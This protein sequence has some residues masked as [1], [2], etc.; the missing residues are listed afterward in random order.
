[1]QMQFA[2][3]PS[4]PAEN[5][6]SRAL[7]RL[8]IARHPYITALFFLVYWL[9]LLLASSRL[10]SPIYYATHMPLL[11]YQMFGEALLALIVI[12]PVALLGWWPEVGL[13]R[14]VNGRGILL[15][16]LPA[17][18]IVGPVLLALPAVVGNAT[19]LVLVVSLVLSLLVGFA[20]EGMFRG[21]ILRSLLPKGIWPA[22]L[23]STL[24]FAS[25]HL[26]N[27]LGGASW[28]YVFDQLILT[29]G[30]GV[31]F[32]ALRLRT[33]SL[34]PGILLHAAR[35]IVGMII[36]G[37]N[38]TVIRFTPSNTTYI[39]TLVFCLIFLFI[40]SVLLRTSQVRKLEIAYGLVRQT[41]AVVPNNLFYSF[42]QGYPAY[43]SSGDQPFPATPSGNQPLPYPGSVSYQEYTSPDAYRTLPPS[44]ETQ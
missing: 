14:G 15:C 1:M 34:W 3:P 37:M 27:L 31:L 43:P 26:T 5:M 35:D 18:L 21:V 16:L 2:P 25:V 11:L 4:Q 29:V 12:L 38:P 9:A 24:C 39:N 32:A 36:Q 30:I 33:G 19:T 13:A 40:S 23:L 41:A 7:L 20:E 28:G 44:Q 22:V 17:L 6:R 8:L 42:P 10:L